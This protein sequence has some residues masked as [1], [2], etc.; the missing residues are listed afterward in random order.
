M[1][2]GCCHENEKLA[3]SSSVS[4]ERRTAAAGCSMSSGK[5]TEVAGSHMHDMGGKAL[6]PLPVRKYLGGVGRAR[7]TQLM[8]PER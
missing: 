5:R 2:A 7:K 3:A 4:D 8:K 6:R 1:A